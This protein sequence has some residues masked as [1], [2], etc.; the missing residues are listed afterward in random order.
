MRPWHG[1]Q[2]IDQVLAEHP[3]LQLYRLPGYSHVIERVWKVLRRR[4]TQNR[5]FASMV[6][7]KTALRHSFCYDQKM[8][9]KVRSLIEHPK[10]AAKLAV[11]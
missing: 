3:H 11:A 4:A 5:L 7:L 9:H 6:E 10:K 8:R 1:G 2:V